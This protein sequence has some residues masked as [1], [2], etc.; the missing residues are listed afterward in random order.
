MSTN[1][2]TNNGVKWEYVAFGA[3]FAIVFAFIAFFLYNNQT[4]E[5][6]EVKLLN[7]LKQEQELNS[8]L[9]MMVKIAYENDT[10]NFNEYQHDLLKAV[11][12][13]N[14]HDGFA[15]MNLKHRKVSK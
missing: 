1:N 6:R 7:E 11:I 5:E 14:I 9:R 2:S 10:T 3:V 15:A 12:D 4:G 8:T 13:N